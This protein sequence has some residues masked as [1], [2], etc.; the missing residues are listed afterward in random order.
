MVKDMSNLPHQ[1]RV[2]LLDDHAVVRYGTASRLAQEADLLIVGSYETSSGMIHGLRSAPADV[3]LVD[4][5][6][7]PDDPDGAS[8][9]RALATKF[10]DTAILV[11]S[12]HSEP[13]TAAL[14]F[15]M[16]ARGFVGKTQGMAQLV[17]AIR[18]VATKAL[19][20][21][22][23]MSYLLE[24]M[25]NPCQRNMPEI[26]ID[27][28]ERL[29]AG[30]TLSTKEREVIRCLLGGMTVREIATKFNRSAKTI[31]TQKSTAF[32]KLGVTSDIG[33]FKILST[34]DEQ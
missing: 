33:L 6:L 12:A 21:D 18:K 4:Y 27:R 9:I 20:L 30:T 7:G 8:L 10:P 25:P 28:T 22:P 5:S 14:A 19:Y 2:A 11:F 16:G 26:Q 31:S 23:K 24:E 13:A 3:L 34:L 32:R 15:R 29:I 17:R 1:I